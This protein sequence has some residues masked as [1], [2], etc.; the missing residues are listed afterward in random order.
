M[1]VEL[2][3][4]LSKCRLKLEIT[5]QRNRNKNEWTGPVRGGNFRVLVQ[6]CKCIASYRTLPTSAEDYLPNR[7]IVTIMYNSRRNI[8]SIENDIIPC[9]LWLS[10]KKLALWDLLQFWHASLHLNHKR[11]LALPVL[12]ARIHALSVFHYY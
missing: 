11:E 6:L 1:N 2:K 7:F 5:R 9:S 12:F 3:T 8:P 4:K 10:K